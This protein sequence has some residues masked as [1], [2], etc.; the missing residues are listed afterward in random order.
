MSGLS[1]D[2]AHGL[3]IECAKL[4]NLESVRHDEKGICSTLLGSRVGKT[5]FSTTMP[6][7]GDSR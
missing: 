5:L 4:L 7:P 6:G 3:G 1:V 2:D